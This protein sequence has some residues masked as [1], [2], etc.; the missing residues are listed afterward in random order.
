[1]FEVRWPGG[2]AYGRASMESYGQFCAVARALEILGERWTL[3]VVRELLLGSTGFNEIRRGLPRIPTATLAKR[4]QTLIA[5][6]VVEVDASRY[7]LTPAGRA[8][9]PV[10][11]D[12]ATWALG[13]GHVPLEAGHLDAAALSWDIQRRIDHAAVP[14]RKI[15]IA[16]HFV[17]RAVGDSLYWLQLDRGRANL[18]ATDTGDPVDVTL[19]AATADVV[20][21]WLGE[22]SWRHLLD[23]PDTEITG[24]RAVIRALPSWFRGYVLAAGA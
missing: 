15:T 16:L 21:W 11:A 17:D 1:M 2:P 7:V 12:M 13:P 3:L 22:R 5:A 14:D 4:L 24:S 10:V 18:C 19:R 23:Q 6:G 9:R 8:L 20:R